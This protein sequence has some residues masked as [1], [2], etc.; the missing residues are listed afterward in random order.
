MIWKSID[1]RNDQVGGVRCEMLFIMVRD[2]KC[3]AKIDGKDCKML[4]NK[5]TEVIV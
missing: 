3:S 1:L 2:L 5:R 4:Q